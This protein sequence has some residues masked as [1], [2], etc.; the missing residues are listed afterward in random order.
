MTENSK[1]L[2]CRRFFD[3]C[4]MRSSKFRPGLKTPVYTPTNCRY[5][6]PPPTPYPLPPPSPLGGSYCPPFV[7]PHKTDFEP[8]WDWFWG[9]SWSKIAIFRLF[10]LKF[11]FLKKNFKFLKKTTSQ[12]KHEVKAKIWPSKTVDFDLKLHFLHL[13]GF[14]VFMPPAPYLD[15]ILG[16]KTLLKTRIFSPKRR[17]FP[18]KKGGQVRKMTLFLGVQI[19]PK[20]QKFF[21]KN[22]L[23]EHFC[24]RVCRNRCRVLW[25]TLEKHVVNQNF[26]NPKYFKNFW[27]KI[28]LLNFMLWTRFPT[29][30]AHSRSDFL[31]L[32]KT[33]STFREL[34]KKL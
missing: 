6:H 11:L 24:C 25:S 4:D 23:F 31:H 19:P 26:Q 2:F 33:F 7:P 12:E 28:F 9:K 20:A 10:G 3:L 1:S 22:R 32:F 18:D 27:K 30:D 17:K 13:Q 14:V 34:F 16:L 15:S 29:Y 5:P 21:S 8:F